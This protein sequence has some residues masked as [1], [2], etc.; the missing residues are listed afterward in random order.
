MAEMREAMEALDTAFVL[1]ASNPRVL[2]N[3]A[4]L[5][6]QTRDIDRGLASAERALGLARGDDQAWHILALLLS[7]KNKL[8]D[9]R[10]AT[11]V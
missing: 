7:S 2:V 1:D 9:A 8:L 10:A 3:L 6:G 5:Y 4:V 11:Q